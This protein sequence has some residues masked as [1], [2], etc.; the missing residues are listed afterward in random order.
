[1]RCSSPG[2]SSS[3]DSAR[4]DSTSEATGLLDPADTMPAGRAAPGREHADHADVAAERDG[5][6]AVLGLAALPGPDR[7]AE[8]DHVLGHADAEP[9]GRDQVA[10]LVQ[11]DGHRDA[12]DDG[13]D[14]EHVQ[15]DRHPG[16]LRGRRAARL[17]SAREPSQCRSRALARPRVRGHDVL[18]VP[19]R[20][21]AR[22]RGPRR[23]HR[24]PCRRSGGSGGS[25]RGTRRRRPRW[26]R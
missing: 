11:G 26:P 13:E 1:M 21:Q 4:A 12:D 10:D 25:R 14:A 2:R 18:D 24:P 8:A 6:D 7:R 5:L 9:L 3:S 20:R 17:A 22:R 23:G 16:P 19:R 15:Q